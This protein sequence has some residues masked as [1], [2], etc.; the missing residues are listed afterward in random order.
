M[1]ATSLLAELERGLEALHIK[2]SRD[3]EQR[4]LDYLALLQR[5]NRVYNLTAVRGGRRML[6]RHVLDSLTLIPHVEGQRILDVGSGAGLPGVPL[7]IC[8]PDKSFWLLDAS[9]KRCRFLRQAKA[10]LGLQNV[11]VVAARAEDYQSDEKFDTLASRAFSSLAGFVRSA[12]HL[13]AENGTL[14]AMKGVWPGQESSELANGFI[15]EN[16]VRTTVPG[17]HEE[18]H[19]VICR[20]THDK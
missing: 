1:N 2:L 8:M 17:L 10:D 16:V 15:I 3:D 18:R 4:L 6:T 7:A 11:T 13:L 19:L 5:W 20:R 12:G 9:A 14:L